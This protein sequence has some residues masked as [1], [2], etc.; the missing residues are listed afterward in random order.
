MKHPENEVAVFWDYENV[1][2]NAEGLKVPVAEKL[3]EFSETIGHIRL[4]RVYSDW[5]RVNPAIN[6]ALY[7]LGFDPIHVSM[8]KANSVD[9]KIAVDCLD[10]AIMYPEINN[11]IIVTGD[12]DFISVVN[13]LKDNHRKV[14]IIGKSDVVSEHLLLSANNFVSLEEFSKL[15]I[16][17][18]ENLKLDTLEE[19]LLKLDTLE[20]EF[21]EIEALLKKTSSK[22]QKIPFNDAVNCLIEVIS[23]ARDQNKSSRF[24][25]IDTLMRANQNYD[26][27]G[28]RSIIPP[29]GVK[30]FKT[31]TQFIEKVEKLGKIKFETIEGFRELFLIEEDPKIESEFS[32]GPQMVDNLEDWKIII[33]VLEDKFIEIEEKF[34][35]NYATFSYLFIGLRNARKS[36]TKTYS[37]RVLNNAINILIENEILQKV[38]EN[39]IVFS[40]NYLD[41]LEES[42]NKIIQKT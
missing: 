29:N 14:T 17:D 24:N 42:L 20:E 13:W 23:K 38:E 26:Y 5:S 21:P 4:K 9:V 27:R 22:K 32:L 34:E 31:F 16:L 35:S 25:T 7:S 30:S 37:N 41:H 6:R 15:D 10:T 39:H 11:F 36:L 18:E 28:V 3:V 12:K 8:G 40:P 1:R 33:G 2:V 19:E